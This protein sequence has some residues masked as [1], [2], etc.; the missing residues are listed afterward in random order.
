MAHRFAA[1]TLGDNVENLTYTGD[2]SFTDVGNDLD[3]VIQGG[4]GADTLAGGLGF[5]TLIGGA[6]NDLYR[7]DDVADL[8][9]E[10]PPTRTER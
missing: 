8:V 3:N 1:Y 5:D 4:G 9:V 7:I 6:G 10:V 2:G